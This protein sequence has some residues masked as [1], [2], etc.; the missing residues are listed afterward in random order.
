MLLSRRKKPNTE[1]L[2]K[3]E[4]ANFL[5]IRKSGMFR[6]KCDSLI[7]CEREKPFVVQIYFGGAKDILSAYQQHAK[8][9]SED[10]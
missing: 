5:D 6:K 1:S 7:W 9:K 8:G 3:G 4:N 2:R 10:M